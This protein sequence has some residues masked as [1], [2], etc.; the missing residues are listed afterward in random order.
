MSSR[1]PLT[2][3]DWRELARIGFSAFIVLIAAIIILSKAYPDDQL[4]WAFGI[5]G[6]VLGYWLK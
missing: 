1:P 3:K 6:V 4:K 5:I 2:T